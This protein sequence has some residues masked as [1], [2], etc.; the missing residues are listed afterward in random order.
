MLQGYFKSIPKEIE[1]AG[2][3]D[4]QNWFGII[5]KIIIPL[6]FILSLQY[7]CMSL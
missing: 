5:I 3:I 2:L 7:H 1:E 6:S 4:G